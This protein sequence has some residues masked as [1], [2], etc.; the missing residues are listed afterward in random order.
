MEAALSAIAKNL[1]QATVL[2]S[3]PLEGGISA[4]MTAF[5]L[6]LGGGKLQTV[7]AR[8]PGDWAKGR[9][10]KIA[11]LEFSRLQALQ[12]AGLPVPN[13]RFVSDDQEF[14]VIDFIEG[15]PE[16]N[17]PNRTEFLERYA[18]QLA[19]IHR[20][21]TSAWTDGLFPRQAPGVSD[22]RP[23]P[24]QR[25]QEARVHQWLSAHPPAHPNPPVLRHGDFWPGNVIW[26]DGEIRGVIDWEE[27]CIGEPLADFCI[28]RL[29]L[30]WDH[31]P[32]GMLEFTQLYQAEMD[33]DF[34]DVPYWDLVASLRPMEDIAYW[35]TA[36]GPLGR[37]DIT[38]E[39]MSRDLI[40][41]I[42]QAFSKVG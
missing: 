39:T 34:T 30:L 15:K 28:C 23:I 33:L 10:P 41:F 5:E 27:A 42:D 18:T 31:G 24:N 21:D 16:L 36:N 4:T 9:H 22:P 19:R 38:E 11:Q 25:F 13:P 26:K 37:P 7:I 8:E 17:P 20:T 32:Q 1:P 6:D 40:W 3:W 35:A 12:T 2:R 14:Y 29:D